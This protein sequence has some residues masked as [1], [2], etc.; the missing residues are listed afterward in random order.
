MAPGLFRKRRAPAAHADAPLALPPAPPP[1]STVPRPPPTTTAQTATTSIA[2][3]PRSYAQLADLADEIVASSWDPKLPLH[4]WL[5]GVGKLATESEVCRNEGNYDMAFVRAATVLK[6]LNEVLPYHHPDWRT[7][8][9][10]Q[11][12]LARQQV[13]AASSLYTAL[14]THLIRRTTSFYA[15]RSSASSSRASTPTPTSSAHPPSHSP[16]L[17]LRNTVTTAATVYRDGPGPAHGPPPAPGAHP[18]R[19]GLQPHEP[20]PPRANRLRAAFSRAHSHPGSA[21]GGAAGGRAAQGALP[22]PGAADDAA[23]DA[24]SPLG[25]SS[26]D[27]LVPR[28]Q[29]RRIPKLGEAIERAPLAPSSAG[30]NAPPRG[31]EAAAQQPSAPMPLPGDDDGSEEDEGAK[32][33]AQVPRGEVVGATWAHARAHAAAWPP[34]PLATPAYGSTAAAG[35]SVGPSR[36]NSYAEPAARTAPQAAPPPSL[37]SAWPP[38]QHHYAHASQHPHP[39]APPAPPSQPAALGSHPPQ[40]HFPPP[41]PPHLVPP[42]APVAPHPPSASLPASRAPPPGPSAPPATTPTPEPFLLPKHDSL[43]GPPAPSAPSPAPSSPSPAPAASLGGGYGSVGALA[44]SFAALAVRE[45]DEV[46]AGGGAGELSHAAEP[47]A[48]NEAGVPL[49]PVVLPSRLISHFMHVVAAHNTALNIETCGLLLG[50]QHKD[51]KF[52]VSHLLVPKQE[53]TSDTCTATNDEET[54]AFQEQR[55]LMTLGWIHTHPTQSIFLSSLDLHTHL[56]F[57]LLLREAIAVVCAPSA[58]DDEPQCGVFRMTDPPGM[59]A[60]AACSE[61]G[62]FHP[63]PPLP[64][65]TDVDEEGGHCHVDDAAS[66][67]CVDLR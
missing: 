22:E 60:V 16:A 32:G 52:V 36:P 8:T 24:G 45:E 47:V 13:A 65:Y 54:F 62:A 58:L 43:V 15:S 1:A 63:H 67:E 29:G 50:T 14:K 64:L 38:T 23:E 55:G 11:L 9:S 31:Y 51:G 57:Q 53:G 48:R 5:D 28:G 2:E 25:L 56:G 10:A 4:L 35:W 30:W 61:G 33:A 40:P 39:H 34:P 7:L 46:R 59:G 44:Q 42:V 6:L 3:P 21:A 41:F 37:D 27:E 66:F 26:V 18:R 49:R 19:S 17:T 20:A 12:E